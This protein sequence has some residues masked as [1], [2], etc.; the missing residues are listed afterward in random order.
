MAAAALAAAE[1]QLVEQEA[2]AAAAALE[3]EARCAAAA[4]AAQQQLTAAQQQA[5]QQLTAAQRQVVAA[6]QQ[7]Q[8]AQAL[9]HPVDDP[10]YVLADFGSSFFKL[11]YDR[12][13][14]RTTLVEDLL[15]AVRIDVSDKLEQTNCSNFLSLL[16][17]ECHLEQFKQTKINGDCG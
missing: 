6:Q 10:A 7:A 2:A 16:R 4:A 1:A 12:I 8:A 3:Q 13:A 15:G 11:R 5:Q 9:L 17:N 14:P